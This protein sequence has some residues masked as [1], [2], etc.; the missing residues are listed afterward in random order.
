M[1]EKP[2]DPVRE[3]YSLVI[4]LGFMARI[5]GSVLL[6]V[7]SWHWYERLEVF[8]WPQVPVFV[9][10]AVVEAKTVY[11][12]NKRAFLEHRPHILFRYE[13]RNTPYSSNRVTFDGD[14]AGPNLTAAQI[15]VSAALAAKHGERTLWASINP[16]EPR[17]A[18]LFRE[19]GH[20][21]LLFFTALSLGMVVWGGFAA[22]I[23]YTSGSDGEMPWAQGRAGKIVGTGVLCIVSVPILCKAPAEIALGRGPAIYIALLLP[24]GAALSIV[25]LTRK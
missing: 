9:E 25:A 19:Q 16:T 4:L 2:A 7:A 1:S 18:I 20:S 6:G 3:S 10:A 21:G 22:W 15:Q 17:E 13:W 8:E 24:L 5:V 11:G 23:V 14:S 12:R